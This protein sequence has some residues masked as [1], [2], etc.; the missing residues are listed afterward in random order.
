MAFLLAVDGVVEGQM[1]KTDKDFPG[2]L[3]EHLP[4]PHFTSQLGE[5][6]AS[7]AEYAYVVT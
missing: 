6:Q 7:S 2:F 1:D 3:V 5:S 4:K